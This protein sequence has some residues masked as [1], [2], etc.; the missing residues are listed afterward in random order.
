M[1]V[2]KS[3]EFPN[4]LRYEDL[5]KAAEAFESVFAEVLMKSSR[6]FL[7]GRGTGGRSNPRIAKPR[8]AK[9]VST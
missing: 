8:R 4:A 6:R 2:K 7:G 1:S 5:K 3:A 9:S